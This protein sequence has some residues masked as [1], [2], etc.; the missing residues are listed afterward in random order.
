MAFIFS[1]TSA[2]NKTLI[3]IK[4]CFIDKV[5]SRFLYENPFEKN[6]WAQKKY[7]QLGMINLLLNTRWLIFIGD[8]TVQCVCVFLNLNLLIHTVRFNLRRFV[9][10][11]EMIAVY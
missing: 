4:L 9:L 10:M 2:V 3:L 7:N 11:L 1:F 5:M 6:M 8:L